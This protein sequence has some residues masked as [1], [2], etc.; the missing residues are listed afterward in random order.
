MCW[1][2]INEYAV[3]M[4]KPLKLI[5]TVALLTDLPEE[6]LSIGQVGIIVEELADGVYDVEF[7]NAKGRT[8]TT[9]AV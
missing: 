8:L 3:G 4:N 5:D 2:G 6:R 9:C 7:A 1:F